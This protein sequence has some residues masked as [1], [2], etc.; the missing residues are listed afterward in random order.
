MSWGPRV[1]TAS[2]ELSEAL[3]GWQ[4]APL[5][6]SRGGLHGS[7]TEGPRSQPGT[8]RPLFSQPEPNE[9]CPSQNLSAQTGWRPPV[10]VFG[11]LTGIDLKGEKK[12]EQ[13]ET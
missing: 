10:H 7:E 5:R 8:G 11:F 9:I 4:S 2:T 6:G 3:G 1:R 13:G 12:P